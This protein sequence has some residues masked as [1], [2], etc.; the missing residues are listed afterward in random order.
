MSIRSIF[1]ALA[2]YLALV[3]FYFVA[4]IVS[5]MIVPIHT[6]WNPPA[7][8]LP[9]VFGGMLLRAAVNT[10]VIALIVARSTWRGWRLF[11]GLAFAWY[12]TMTF[13]AQ[14]EAYWFAPS[15]GLARN[16]PIELAL[17]E[18]PLVLAITLVAVLAWGRAR[19]AEPAPDPHNRLPLSAAEWL[20]KLAVIA[21]LYLALYFGFGF[22]VAWQNPALR[23]MYNDGADPI[24]FSSAYLLPLQVAR[25]AL[26]V[27]FAL[28]V[29]RMA[30][31]SAWQVALLVGL[32]FALPM[33]IG[34]AIPN[35]IMPDPSVRLS[36]FVETTT[37]NFI[38]GLCVTWLLGWR[39]HAAPA[40][41]ARPVKL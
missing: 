19:P 33:N 32:L 15:L 24:V 2:K 16:V 13:M 21:A 26:W 1:V 40:R 7:E 18:L 14:I 41:S 8:Q 37:S 20:W 17:K 12:G 39:N 11:A 27:L 4:D 3:V 22:M 31:G 34:H 6:G 9:W 29:I 23:A 28:P 35:P 38:F 36:H 10:L 30:R 5:G 25:S